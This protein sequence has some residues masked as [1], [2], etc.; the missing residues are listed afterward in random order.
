MQVGTLGV[1]QSDSRSGFTFLLH[2]VKASEV[3]RGSTVTFA[4][5]RFAICGQEVRALL[6]LGWPQKSAA[7]GHGGG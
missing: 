4:G 3:G 7:A 1:M 6:L 2:S 5:G